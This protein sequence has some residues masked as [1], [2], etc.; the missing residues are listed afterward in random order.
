[1]RPPSSNTS[2]LR[3]KHDMGAKQQQA[4]SEINVDQRGAADDATEELFCYLKT[5]LGK[6]KKHTLIIE[7]DVLRMQRASSS[8]NISDRVT[9]SLTSKD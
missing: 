5:R 2:V 6:Y 4:A 8:S 7:N 9:T 3:Q 1:M